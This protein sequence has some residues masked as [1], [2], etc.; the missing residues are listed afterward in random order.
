[1]MSFVLRR[2][3]TLVAVEDAAGSGKMASG[4]PL[5]VGEAPFMILESPD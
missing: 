5:C 3:V 1:M 2:S 4:F